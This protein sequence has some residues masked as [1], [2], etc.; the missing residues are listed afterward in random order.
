MDYNE[1]AALAA[2][3]KVDCVRRVSEFEGITFFNAY[4]R[5]RE[6]EHIDTEGLVL[7]LQS[8]YVI[9]V[10]TKWWLGASQHKYHRWWGRQQHEDEAARRL[11]KHRLMDTQELRAVVDHLPAE[12]SPALMLN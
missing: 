9:K 8:G 10:K 4:T 1:R 12:V 5:Y 3:Y 6:Q 7:R 2:M 11:K